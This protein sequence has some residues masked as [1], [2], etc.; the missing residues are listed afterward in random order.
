[1][2]KIISEFDY[3]DVAVIVVKFLVKLYPL[4]CL[5]YNSA[6]ITLLAQANQAG[7]M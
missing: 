2:P 4:W 3:I 6:V 5:H 1:M 7:R